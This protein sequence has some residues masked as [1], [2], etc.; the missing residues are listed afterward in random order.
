MMI[1]IRH[2]KRKGATETIETQRKDPAEFDIPKTVKMLMLD[3][4]EEVTDKHRPPG[5][6]DPAKT[7]WSVPFASFS[8][9]NARACLNSNV[10]VMALGQNKGGKSPMGVERQG[11]REV[12]CLSGSPEM[13]G[14]NGWSLEF[15]EAPRWAK[16]RQCF[17]NACPLQ[18]GDDV[19]R[20]HHVSPWPVSSRL[21]VT[22]SLSAMRLLP[23]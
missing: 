17:E 18:Q 23:V 16:S 6:V 12:D 11:E 13:V 10:L 1:L 2:T 15:A 9:P 21:H 8:S 4:C 22:L 7:A 3:L 14:V 19:A 20:A 5:I